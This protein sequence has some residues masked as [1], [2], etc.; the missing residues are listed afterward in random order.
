[1]KVVKQP[2]VL[3][4]VHSKKMLGCVKI[5]TNSTLGWKCNFEMQPS[6]WVCPYLTQRWVKTTQH[7]LECTNTRYPLCLFEEKNGLRKSAFLFW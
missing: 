6:G 7:F 3:G 2:V 4:I 5:C 1:M